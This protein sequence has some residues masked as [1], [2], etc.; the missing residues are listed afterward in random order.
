[1]NVMR[2]AGLKPLFQGEAPADLE[3]IYSALA[4]QMLW[5]NMRELQ[6]ALQRYG[7]RLSVVEPRE[8]K[9]Q[10]TAAYLDIKRRQ[11]L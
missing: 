8:I 5:N 6:I 2:T 10:V 1:V 9:S 11:L 3:S 4:G 7:V